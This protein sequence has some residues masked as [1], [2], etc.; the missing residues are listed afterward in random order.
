[1][2]TS[3]DTG[4]FDETFVAN[5]SVHIERMDDTAYWIGIYTPDGKG[6]MVNTGVYRGEWYFNVEEDSPDG[7][8]FTVRR[9]RNSKRSLP[10]HSPQAPGARAGRGGA[11]RPASGGE[12]R[13]GQAGA[14]AG[15]FGGNA[16]SRQE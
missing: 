8:S 15:M 14:K 13:T 12:P 2:K 4:E 1:M 16:G 11:E 7:R 5:A 10:K 9:P 6:I 3:I